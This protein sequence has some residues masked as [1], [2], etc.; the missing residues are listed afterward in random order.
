[1]QLQISRVYLALWLYVHLC[2]LLSFFPP[3]KFFCVLPL[4]LSIL[5]NSLPSHL[6]PLLCPDLVLSFQRWVLNS[7]DGTVI[8]TDA[9]LQRPE[10]RARTM[11]VSEPTLKHTH[12]LS[13]HWFQW[14]AFWEAVIV[15][16]HYSNIMANLYNKSNLHEM[17]MFARRK[18]SGG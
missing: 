10:R 14:D 7:P 18:A 16:V 8:S 15:I 4:L 1:M 12:S 9:L 6:S 5:P 3:S 2:L 11:V 13:Y 17:W